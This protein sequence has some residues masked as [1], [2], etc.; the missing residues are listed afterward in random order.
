MCLY[1][2]FLTS[3]KGT[4]FTEFMMN[5]LYPE[6]A[7]SSRYSIKALIIIVIIVVILAT[8]TKLP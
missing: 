8:I 5:K 2:V 1:L 7:R 4:Y 3:E 6:P